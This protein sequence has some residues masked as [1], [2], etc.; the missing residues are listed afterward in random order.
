[1]STSWKASPS[2]ARSTSRAFS[3]R[4]QPSAWYRT[5]L[6]IDAAGDRGLRDALDGQPVRREAHRDVLR[7]VERPGL[8]ERARR[9]V[10]Q[11]RVHLVPLPEVLLEA[12]HPL[13][14]GDEEPAGVAED[15]RED[16]HA[17]LL[18]DLV[19]GRRDW[20]V[21]ALDE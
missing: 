9:D 18:E 10:V 21:R 8:V 14:V 12:L 1:M 6:R 7:L 19:R 13:E 2:S 15:V 4:W 20:A 16:E 5:T 11:L 17:L 3:Q